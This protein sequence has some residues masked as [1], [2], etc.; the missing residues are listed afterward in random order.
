VAQAPSGPDWAKWSRVRHASL[1]KLVLLSLD[2]DPD[3]GDL[4]ADREGRLAIAMSRVNELDPVGRDSYTLVSFAAMAVRLGWELPAQFPRPSAI[5]TTRWPWGEHHT[6]LLGC[7][8]DAGRQFW[9]T[10]D[11]AQP[12]TAPT[13]RDVV[14]YLRKKGVSEATA[15]AMA[16]MLRP[17]ELPTGRRRGSG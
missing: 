7:L 11:S 1:V 12:G 6:H 2:C 4:S 8:A 9:T 13:N 16:T 10:Y 15:K 17:P 3:R 5:A 14:A